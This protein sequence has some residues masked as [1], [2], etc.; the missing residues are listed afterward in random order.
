MA[1][2]TL[3]ALLQ[4]LSADGEVYIAGETIHDLSVT[5]DIYTDNAYTTAWTSTIAVNE[6]AAAISQAEL[7]GMNPADYHQR[8]VQDLAD[9]SLKLDAA[10]RDLLLTD[11][12]VRLTYHY[13]FGKVDP[14]DYNSS[15]NFDRTLPQVDP[16]QWARQVSG[17]GG[18]LAGLTKLKPTN[19][20]YQQLVRA[21]AK[22]RAIAATGGWP[23]VDPGPT[24]HPGDAGPRVLQ[25]RRRLLVE[26]DMGEDAA[27]DAT[28]FDGTLKQA[29][30]HFQQRY[31]L[32]TDGVLGKQ[33]LAAMN[34]SVD[35]RI[36]QIRVNL[37]RS[38]MLQDIPDT[39]VV[40]DIAG[41]EVSLFRNGKRLLRSRAQVGRPYRSTPTFRDRITYIEFN[42]T[43]TVPPTILVKDTLPA[44]KRDPG[45]LQSK[46]MQVLTRDGTEVDPA[47]VN[48]QL[49]PQRGFPYIIR[50]RPGPTNSLGRLKVMFPNEHMVYLH[51]TPSRDLFSRSERTFSSGCIRVEEIM[52]L[53][54]L[55][56]DDPAWDQ[57]AIAKVID[58]R[59]TKRVSLRQ[60]V[61]IY[62]VYWTVQVQDDGTVEFKR[63]PYQRDGALLDALNRP[64]RPDP[65]RMKQHRPEL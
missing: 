2:N 52:E 24:L 63:D 58:E 10:A 5:Q 17:N 64:L 36:G 65:V 33:T 55:L 22:Y 43:W 12:L 54:E 18:I 40:V 13:A 57:A 1:E 48:W 37:E 60:S 62:L 19:P 32:D 3:A 28:R 6:L 50:Q 30:Q 27:P 31:H 4:Q 14:R 51:D 44:I 34:V 47:T 21:L 42:P 35:Q 11:A 16:V 46:N 39:A 25:L 53:A 56:L 23:T 8:Q 41:F 49:Y 29:T 45:Y 15:W 9:G 20:M 59:K 38:R 61:P 26:G 7:E